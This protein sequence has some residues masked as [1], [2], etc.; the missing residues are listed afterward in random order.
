MRLFMT[1]TTIT[2]SNI[3]GP[4]ESITLCGHPVVFMAASVYGHPQALTVHFLNYGSTIKVTLAV[5]DAQFPDCHQ[6]L[7]D[8]AESIGLI[9]DAADLQTST[10]I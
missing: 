6:L 5:D 1:R 8:F 3:V 4:A 10:S 2:L 9:K 7:D